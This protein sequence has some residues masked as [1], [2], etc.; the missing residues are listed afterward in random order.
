MK[1]LG[2]LRLFSTQQ[3]VDG[4]AIS[5]TLI[6]AMRTSPLELGTA[7]SFAPCDLGINKGCGQKIAGA[8]GKWLFGGW[9]WEANRPTCIDQNHSVRA[10]CDNASQHGQPECPSQKNQS[11]GQYEHDADDR[12]EPTAVTQLQRFNRRCCGGNG[13]VGDADPAAPLAPL[14]IKG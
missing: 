8:A 4:L 12:T 14:G 5:V 3:A 2:E 7:I 1:P 9:I 13:D 6:S 10:G 11:A